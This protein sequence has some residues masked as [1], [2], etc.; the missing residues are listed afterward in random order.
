MKWFKLIMIGI[1]LLLVGVACEGVSLERQTTPIAPPAT[2]GDLTGG[3]AQFV[4]ALRAEG[5]TVEAVGQV[6]QP[7]FPV[8]GQA[9]RVNGAEVQVFEFN[10]EQSRRE[11]ESTLVVLRDAVAQTMGA[12][13]GQV[14]FWSDGRLIVLYIGQDAVLLSQLNQ[15]LGEPLA[16]PAPNGEPLPLPVA[17]G[18][19]RVSEEL[20]IAA[21]NFRVIRFEQV[22][23]SDGCL[24]LGR[25]D[26]GCLMAI[27]PGWRVIVEAQGQQYEIR[28]DMSGSQV[29]WQQL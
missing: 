22:D 5:A 13:A 26:E 2:N 8:S 19:Q 29:R 14:H 11:T 6:N 21:E 1:A 17:S 20:A 28:T 9:I 24:G 25:A 18:I 23:W 12:P 16:G 27:T 3:H 4:D 7:F 15:V 10:D